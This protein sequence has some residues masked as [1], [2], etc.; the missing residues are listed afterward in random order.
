MTT[1]LCPTRGGENSYR[2]QQRAIAIAQERDALLLYLFVADVEFL[3][4]PPV[5]AAGASDAEI[6]AFLLEMA[7]KRAI[8][9]GVRSETVVKQG[10]FRKALMET[11]QEYD[12]DLVILGSPRPG[13]GSLTKIEYLQDL[14]R[15]LN[16][17]YGIEAMIV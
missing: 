3:N 5:I 8:Q 1:I 16:Q 6:E 15:Q 11:A 13:E 17:D 4:Q 14:C 2:T 9:E 12:V 10:G 7:K